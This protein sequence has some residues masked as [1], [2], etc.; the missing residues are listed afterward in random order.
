MIPVRVTT[1]PK[2]IS[3]HQGQHVTFTCSATGPPEPVITWS[4][5]QGNLPPLRNIVSG[6]KLTI[7]NVT[8]QDSG[9]Y[10]CNATN[11]I[12]K[13]YS[14][15][16]LKVYCSLVSINIPTSSVVLYVGQ[17]VKLS[18][19]ASVG[20][21]VVW[22]H[23]G[24]TSLPQEALIEA[25]DAL[26]IPSLSK[27]HAGNFSCVSGNSVFLNVN[28]SLK[29]PET[30]TIVKQHT[31]DVSRHYVIDPDGGQGMAP[32]TVYCNM[33]DKGGIGV[34][35]VSQN[36]KNRIYVHGFEARGSYSRNI[37][38]SASAS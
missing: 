34:T 38:Y 17:A 15:V 1:S 3:T 4:K 18:C 14:S 22:M 26:I 19:P 11:A 23:N 2:S 13:N 20:A 12:S 21:V 10:V 32:F 25:P 9:S 36:S 7:M 31:C 37:Q 35:S 29:N 30:C 6:G 28:L 33:T 8:R 16:E 24:T 27:D 5:S